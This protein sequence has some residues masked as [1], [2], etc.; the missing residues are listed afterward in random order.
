M[1][2][3][4]TEDATPSLTPVTLDNNR[5]DG[6]CI[7]PTCATNHTLLSP[8]LC[9]VWLTLRLACIVCYTR[10]LLTWRHRCWGYFS[11]NL[12]ITLV[13]QCITNLWVVRDVSCEICDSLLYFYCLLWWIMCLGN[14]HLNTI[15]TLRFL[16]SIIWIIRVYIQYFWMSTFVCTFVYAGVPQIR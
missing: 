11:I 2:R 13:G 3:S 1:L 8:H 7:N 15:Q 9:Q 6:V 14:R 16:L 12:S 10:Q 4:T 5:L